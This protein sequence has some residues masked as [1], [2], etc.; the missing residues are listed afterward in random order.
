MRMKKAT[1]FAESKAEVQLNRIELECKKVREWR[2]SQFNTALKLRSATRTRINRFY[3][4][5]R[6]SKPFLSLVHGIHI[7]AMEREIFVKRTNKKLIYFDAVDLIAF[8][9]VCG[10]RGVE[11]K[12]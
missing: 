12:D 11:I 7:G 9:S 3:F 10:C 6:S 1:P 5:R 4:M 8:S 2:L